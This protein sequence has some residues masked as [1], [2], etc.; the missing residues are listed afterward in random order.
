MLADLGFR[1]EGEEADTA[2]RPDKAITEK[3]F[4][5]L[6]GFFGKSPSDSAPE[7]GAAEKAISRTQAV[8]YVIDAAGYYKVAAMPDIF[9]TDFADNSELKREDVGFIAVARG[10]KL[11]QG[12]DALFRPYESITRAEAAT[13]AVNFLKASE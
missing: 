5:E 12:D 6:L 11:V 9:I 4:F 1:F 2:F 7:D 13:H 8:K 10:M 3:E